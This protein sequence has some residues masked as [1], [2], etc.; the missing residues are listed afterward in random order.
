MVGCVVSAALRS[1]TVKRSQISYVVACAFSAGAGLG[2][3]AVSYDFLSG[4]RRCEPAHSSIVPVYATGHDY[5][6]Y[7][8]L[9]ALYLAI[10]TN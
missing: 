7:R 9:L 1:E 8:P 10:S 4:L 5:V 2:T 6:R 3:T